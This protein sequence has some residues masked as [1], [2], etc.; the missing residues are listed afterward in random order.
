MAICLNGPPRLSEGYA[1]EP[2]VLDGDPERTEA[3][4]PMIHI[5]FS[6]LKTWL[7]G[8]HPGVSHRHLKAYLNE[9][10]FH[11]NRRFYP[12]RHS[13]LSW[14]SRHMPQHP[15]AA[16]LDPV[17]HPQTGPHLP[18]PLALKG[19]TFQVSL[20]EPCLSGLLPI[21]LSGESTRRC[22]VSHR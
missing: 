6:N 1:H 13:T 12:C 17:P 19:R 16:H 2:L 5:A 22:R 10:V 18:V 15:S 7:L 9:F 20:K 4:L 8:T 3:H 14:G 21:I 11:F